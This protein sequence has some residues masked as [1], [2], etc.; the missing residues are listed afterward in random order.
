MCNLIPA[1]N[2][3]EF[4]DTSRIGMFGISRGHD[5]LSYYE[6]TAKSKRQLP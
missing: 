5:D 2:Q 1:L 3:I 4:A 6:K